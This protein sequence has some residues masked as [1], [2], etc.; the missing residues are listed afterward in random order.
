MYSTALLMILLFAGVIY[1]KSGF[2]R[3]LAV[4][5][6]NTTMPL[7]GM[8]A[9]LIVCHHLGQRTEIPYVSGFCGS[10][11]YIIVAAFFFMSGYG[12]C[13]SYMRK[14]NA[15]MNGF[16][17]KRL[18]KVV[19]LFMFLTLSI[20]VGTQLASG[21]TIVGHLAAFAYR[22]YTPL[23]FSWFIYAII[24]IYIAFR[25]S[26]FVGKSPLRTGV[27]FAGCC[28]VYVIVLSMV[29]CWPIYWWATIMTTSVGYFVALYEA[30]I[31]QLLFGR[32]F[33]TYGLA[34]L[35]L[36]LSFC[37]MCKMRVLPD[38]WIMLWNI[39]QAF[40]IYMVVC[41]FGMVRWRPLLFVGTFSLEL[42]L[43]HGL[44]LMFWR[45]FMGVTNDYALWL[46]TFACALPMAF[47]AN[48]LFR[49]AV[50][51][52]AYDRVSGVLRS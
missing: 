18:S 45:G 33:M 6:V 47:V 21:Q 38:L 40:A 52:R 37:L 23:P 17:R 9:L 28:T 31:R 25:L 10:I 7:R 24:Y 42:Y 16:L 39:L 1:I 11:G 22:G 2:C 12:L 4:F 49:P 27:W 14:G 48:S 26:A 5:D 34:I 13:S 50:F 51:R 20:M 8:F 29:I 3:S 46:L 15:Y 43:V 36:F 30:R 41:T 35:A 44:P 32:C 19:P